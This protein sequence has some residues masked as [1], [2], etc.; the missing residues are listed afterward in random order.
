MVDYLWNGE[1]DCGWDGLENKVVETSLRFKNEMLEI[2]V[3]SPN[4]ETQ[5]LIN[6]DTMRRF[7]DLART[8]SEGLE[9]GGYY[10]YEDLENKNDNAYKLNS[11]ILLGALTECALQIFLAFY[12]EDY[13]RSKWQ[14]W[15]EIDSESVKNPIVDTINDLVRNEIITAAQGRTLKNAIKDKIKEHTVEHPVQ[16][17]MLDEII[18]YYS[19]MELM[20]EDELAYLKQ[21]QSNRNGIHSFEDRNIGSWNDLQYCVRFWCYLLEWILHR[22][23]DIPVYSS[24]K[25]ITG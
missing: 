2:V 3:Y 16:R 4:R 15:E 10:Q 24:R 23:P 9:M 25:S 5:E 6:Q 8:M 14:Q 22:L 20:G 13:R 11:W 17:V 12:I 1:M 18:K 7:V 21:I 19:A